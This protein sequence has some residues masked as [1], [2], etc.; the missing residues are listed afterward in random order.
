MCFVN[1]RNRLSLLLFRKLSFSLS[2]SRPELSFRLIQLRKIFCKQMFFN[3][4]GRSFVFFV[5]LSFLLFA[6]T[7]PPLHDIVFFVPLLLTK[8]N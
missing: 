7:I 4:F 5:F 1:L 8:G 6:L 2:S 3:V